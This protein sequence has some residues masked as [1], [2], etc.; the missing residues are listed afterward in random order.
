MRSTISPPQCN[1]GFSLLE[2]LIAL[3]ILAIGVLGLAGLQTRSNMIEM[4]AY[5]RSIALQLVKDM[6]SRISAS[7]ELLDEIDAETADEVY[8]ADTTLADGYCDAPGT[9]AQQ[10]ACD[11]HNA[12]LGVAETIGA[13]SI[14]APIGMRGCVIEDTQ[15]T[16][17]LR[18]YFVVGV[19]QGLTPTVSPADGTPGAEC[20]PDTDLGAGMRRAIVTRVLI[21]TLTE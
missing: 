7:R 11:W 15:S 14:G 4:E 10:M 17:A 19:W 1:R 20:D 6:A 12:L 21:P 8:G 16:T 9:T 2:V 13:D 5:Q 18:E 3:L